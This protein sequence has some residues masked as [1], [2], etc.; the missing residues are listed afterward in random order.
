MDHLATIFS[1]KRKTI[2]W[3]RVLFY[4]MLDVAGVAAFVIWMSR[5]TNWSLN[6]QRRRRRKFLKQLGQQR[7]DDYIQVRLQNPR[8]LQH[9]D[10]K[11][12]YSFY[13]EGAWKT[14]SVL[15][16]RTHARGH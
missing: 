5:K 14:R 12:R 16:C 15:I 3:P 9:F 2:R 11:L 7:I 1:C 4:N 10:A 13:N 6:V 8:I